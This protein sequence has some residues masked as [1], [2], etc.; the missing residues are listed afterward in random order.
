MPRFSANLSMMFNEVDFPQRFE[1]A[2]RAGFKGVEY[3]FASG[4]DKEDLAE[5]LN[6]NGL[7]HVLYNLPAGDWD[8]GDRG[9]ACHADRTGEFQDGVG[10]A[11]ED[12]I[13]LG[14]KQVNCM[15]GVAP[16][17][18]D[19]EKLRETF[20]ANLKF[21]AAKLGEAGIKLLIEPINTRDIPG[22]YLCHTTQARS[23]IEEVDS[24]NLGLQYDVYHMQIMEGDLARTIEENLDIISH[25]QI[26]DNPGRHEPGTGEVNYPFLFNL[27]D[28]IKY[29]GW[30]GCEYNWDFPYWQSSDP[31]GNP[32]EMMA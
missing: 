27:L 32:N 9:I 19:P 28:E 4:Y 11:V 22:F 15:A 18:A 25:I 23:I 13:V 12:A 30:I 29:S 3:Q 6:E 24:S 8:S 1:A 5:K 31:K 21:A 26:A 14:C 17:G 16:V 20:V 7:T 10:E 2:A